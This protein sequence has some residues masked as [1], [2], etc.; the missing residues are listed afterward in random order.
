[1]TFYNIN[2]SFLSALSKRQVYILLQQV[3]H[4]L[5]TPVNR[6]SA[7]N[8][9]DEFMILQHLVAAGEDHLLLELLCQLT[10]ENTIIQLFHQTVCSEVQ[11]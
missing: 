6:K 8:S 5:G 4:K 11:P 7:V 10:E 1:M 2:A 9:C 3:T